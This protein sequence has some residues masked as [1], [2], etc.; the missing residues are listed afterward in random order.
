MQLGLL[1]LQTFRASIIGGFLFRIGIGAIPFLLPLMLQVGF[2][3]SPLASGSITFIAAVGALCT[4][5]L[6]KRVLELTGFRR[7]LV[8]NALIG[9]VFI[10][11]NGFFTPS[12][13]HWAMM[14]ILFAGGCFRSM[15]FTSIN[16]IAYAD[17][18]HR[19]MSSATSL[20]SVSQQ[21]ALSVGVALGAGA[22]ETS[23]W[24]RGAPS[25]RRER[26]RNRLLDR[27]GDRFAC[28]RLSSCACRRMPGPKCRVTAP[29]KTSHRHRGWSF[30]WNRAEVALS[31]L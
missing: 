7:L 24:M 15:Q 18:S 26:F 19:D 9:A 30:R 17:V 14:T 4:K 11:L 12:T 29:S 1:K 20:S 25:D 31:L 3:L 5:T 13:P 28:R 16:A 22:L 27:G 6:A 10:G 8:V 21:L 23:T 2:G